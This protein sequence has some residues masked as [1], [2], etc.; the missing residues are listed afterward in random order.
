MNQLKTINSLQKSYFLECPS[1][2]YDFLAGNIQGGVIYFGWIRK[3]KLTA[4]CQAK[5][6]HY[7]N[8]PIQIYSKF[9]HQKMK[10]LR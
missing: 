5:V 6:P 1:L 10:I 3:V 2:C 7:E 8:K 4:W 9:Y